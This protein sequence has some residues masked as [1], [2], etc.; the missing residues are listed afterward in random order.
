[1]DILKYADV[2]LTI[3]IAY[4][5]GHNDIQNMGIGSQNSNQNHFAAQCNAVLLAN[6]SKV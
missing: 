3:V 4:N 2:W 1:M 5:S 6:M